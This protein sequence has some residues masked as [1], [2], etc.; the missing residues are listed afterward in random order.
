M[1]KQKIKTQNYSYT[2]K[3]FAFNLSKIYIL[4][5]ILQ[6]NFSHSTLTNSKFLT[7]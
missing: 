2:L 7:N 4:K 1:S 6:N 5:L 3:N